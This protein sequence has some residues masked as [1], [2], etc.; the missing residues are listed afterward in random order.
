MRKIFNFKSLENIKNNKIV[1][2]DLGAN[3]GTVTQKVKKLKKDIKI[4][5]F[6]PVIK[7]FNILQ[8]KF[9]NDKL[10]KLENKAVWF[11]KGKIDF[12]IGIK[13]SH[14]NSKITKIIKELKYNKN[15][16]FNSFEVECIDLNHYI[17]SLNLENNF[18]VM[19]MDIEGAE[20]N[21]LD[22]LIEKNTINNI[23]ILLIEFHR[24][25]YPG[26][27]EELIKKMYKI[28]DSLEIYE[29]QQPGTFI[30]CELRK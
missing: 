22:H 8:S 17:T 25:P 7:N 2:F 5:S 14:T 6:E 29:E 23:D 9:G 27:K 13:N 16:Y 26:K 18:V 4:Y 19:K 20:Y 30:A 21:V 10:I 11:K 1:F 15:K 24:E 28:K 3:V 12:S